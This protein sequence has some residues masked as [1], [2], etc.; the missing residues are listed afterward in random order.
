MP[1][2]APSTCAELRGAV[3]RERESRI[4]ASAKRSYFRSGS[5][6]FVVY[7]DP[8]RAPEQPTLDRAD[9]RMYI[10]GGDWNVWYA[11]RS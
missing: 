8:D 5:L 6:Y 3:E 9:G 10:A 2:S 4:P 7:S 11:L 1:V